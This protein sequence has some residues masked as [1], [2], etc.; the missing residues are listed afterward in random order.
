MT[1]T[2]RS[3]DRPIPSHIMDRPIPSHV[4]QIM[5][6]DTDRPIPSHNHLWIGQKRCDSESEV[7][8][9]HS[10]IAWERARVNV[11]DSSKTESEISLS[12]Q[13]GPRAQAALA[14]TSLSRADS[15]PRHRCNN[16]NKSLGAQ[17]TDPA[18]ETNLLTGKISSQAA[19]AAS[20][21]TGPRGTLVA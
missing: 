19:Q 2:D 21:G 14:L 17:I 20:R 15:L 4:S 10:C 7:P 3:L 5:S 1:R 12:R 13:S 11:V 8:A 16:C 9:A 6:S 18:L